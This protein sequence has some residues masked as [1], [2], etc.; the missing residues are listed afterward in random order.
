MGSRKL[1]RQ[2]FGPRAGSGELKVLLEGAGAATVPLVSHYKHLGT[3]QGPKGGLSAEIAYRTSQAFAAYNEGRRKVYR[4]RAIPPHR[5][6]FILRT[7]VIPKLTFGCGAWSPLTSGDYKKFAG[8]LWRLYRSLLCLRRDQEQDLSFHTCL[9]LV[10]LPS[11][12]NTL[13][14]HRLLYIGQI[15][16][17][18]P[19]ALW[20]LIRTDS[21]YLEQAMDAFRWLHSLV[22]PQ[23]NLPPP[24]TGWEVWSTLMLQKPGRFKSLIKKA[25]SLEQ[26]KHTV[27]AALDGLYRGLA[28]LSKGHTQSFCLSQCREVCIPCR[29]AFATRVSW[30]G[31]AARCHGYRSQAFLLGTGRTCEGCG[32]TYSSPGRLK[33]HLVTASLCRERWGAFVPACEP[34]NQVHAQAPPEVMPGTLR[35]PPVLCPPDNTCQPLLTAL[36]ALDADPSESPDL[37]W[38]LLEEHIAPFETLRRTVETWIGHSDAQPWAQGVGA[39]L[40]LLLD[41]ALICESVQAIP[42]SRACPAD[43]VPAWPSLSPVSHVSSGRPCIFSVPAPPPGLWLPGSAASLTVRQTKAF[44]DW[45]EGACRVIAEAVL[46]SQH[47]PFCIECPGIRKAVG[48]A[49]SWLEDCSFTVQVSR[50]FSP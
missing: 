12:L 47:Q 31:H 22:G 46:L 27:I 8:C 5:K 24:D 21:G 20:A 25:V 10:G 4:A 6:A 45:I 23:A 37:G 9:S 36:L 11:P 28:V 29:R 30:S 35:V 3:M 16:C 48:P 18:G 40:L 44:A 2:L 7:A 32:K 41:P 15:L 38:Q 49:V 17:G 43:I 14:M 13:R 34:P 42:P 26:H 50:I 1:R 39:D 33:R 19:D